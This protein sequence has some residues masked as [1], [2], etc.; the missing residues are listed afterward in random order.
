[1]YLAL[2]GVSFSYIIKSNVFHGSTGFEDQR[3]IHMH[4]IL[5]VFEMD[6]LV[7]LTSIQNY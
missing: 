4:R 1:M 2:K 5:I 7:T 6:E 3:E